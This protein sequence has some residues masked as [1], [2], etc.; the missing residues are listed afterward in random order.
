[1]KTKHSIRCVTT[2]SSGM[3][4]NVDVEYEV[5]SEYYLIMRKLLDKCGVKHGIS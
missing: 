1:M 3:G 5:S 2:L 4:E